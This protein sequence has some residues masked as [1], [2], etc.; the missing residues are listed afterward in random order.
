VSLR[1]RLATVERLRA[2]RLEEAGVDLQRAADA[3]EAAIRH[4]DALTAALH[5]SRNPHRATPPELSSA[6]VHRDR[7]REERA[8][9]NEEID[10]RR[11]LLDGA[12]AA[13]LEARAELRAVQSLHERHR[14]LVAAQ[15]ARREQQASD[16]AAGVQSSRRMLLRRHTDRRRVPT[17][18]PAGGGPG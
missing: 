15:E 12:R 7:L 6:A 4:R 18:C 11:Q 14:E 8:A 10:R 5:G 17:A 3:V 16:E 2:A 9:T 1:F 13:W